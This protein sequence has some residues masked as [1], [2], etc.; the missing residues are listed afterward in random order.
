MKQATCDTWYQEWSNICKQNIIAIWHS[1]STACVDPVHVCTMLCTHYMIRTSAYVRYICWHGHAAVSTWTAAFNLYLKLCQPV[2]CIS[3][4]D[5]GRA[6]YRYCSWLQQSCQQ[7][8]VCASDTKSRGR[9]NCQKPVIMH[10]LDLTQENR[11]SN[12]SHNVERTLQQLSSLLL[13]HATQ[14]S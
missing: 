13:L 8:S 7:M 2:S 12:H 9:K 11:K 3:F 14:R 6:C 1:G 4:L 10:T 5:E